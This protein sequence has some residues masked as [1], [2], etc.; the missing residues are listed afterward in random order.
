MIARKSSMQLLL[1]VSGGQ[2][3]TPTT[4]CWSREQRVT[5]WLVTRNGKCL[6]MLATYLGIENATVGCINHFIEFQIN[7]HGGSSAVN[8][9]FNKFRFFV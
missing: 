4:N 7:V 9:L 6:Y 5:M 3:T 2:C 8:G 1:K